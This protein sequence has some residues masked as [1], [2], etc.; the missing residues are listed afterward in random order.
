[1][2][3]RDVL[4]D[5]SLQRFASLSTEEL[6]NSPD[7]YKTLRQMNG[8]GTPS[9]S[10]GRF[11]RT[12]F[13]KTN[14]QLSTET[15][16]A[17]LDADW[18]M[19]T[20]EAKEILI[21]SSMT[22]RPANEETLH[23][24]ESSENPSRC[25]CAQIA[26]EKYHADPLCCARGTELAFTWRKDGSLEVSQ[27]FSMVQHLSFRIS[28]TFTSFSRLDSVEWKFHGFISTTRHCRGYIF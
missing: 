4:A 15:M 28:S 10:A 5:P 6:R 3:K 16:R 17:S 19:L 11:D 1:V 18:K 8:C 23:I 14:M 13:L 21:G 7:F 2:S 24:I 22:A 25:S 27:V 9:A 12:L 26:P 20:P